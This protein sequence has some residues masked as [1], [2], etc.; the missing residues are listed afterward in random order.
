MSEYIYGCVCCVCVC[1][2]VYLWAPG[3]A[4]ANAGVDVFCTWFCMSKRMCIDMKYMF[5][6]SFVYSF[7][8]QVYLNV[9]P[10]A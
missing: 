6:Y 7:V 3:W 10:L 5:I 8:C 4:R 1:V 2:C 9:H